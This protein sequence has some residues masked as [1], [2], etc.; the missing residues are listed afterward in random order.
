M[1]TAANITLKISTSYARSGVAFA[2]ELTEPARAP[3]TASGSFLP[4]LPPELLPELRWYLEK[5]L[6]E[7]DDAALARSKRVRES[8]KRSGKR[9]FQEL[10]QSNPECRAIWRRVASR[11]SQTRIEIQES[12][13]SSGIPWELLRDPT[14]NHPVCL[15]AAT[16]VRSRGTS[17]PADAEPLSKLKVLLVISRPGGTADVELR[18]I[19]STI[20]GALRSGSRFEVD[21]LRPPTYEALKRTLREA[22][23]RNDP[24][25]LVHFDGHGFYQNAGRTDAGQEYGGGYLVFEHDLAEHGEPVSGDAFGALATE[26][27]VSAVVLN[28]CRS[29]YQESPT[30]GADSL[31]Q[32]ASSFSHALLAAGVSAAVAMSFN[33]YVTSAKTFMEEFYGQL[34]KG[35][36]FSAAA[37]RA[38]K[39]LSVDRTR[40]HQ[41]SS[42]IDDWLVPAVYQAGADLTVQRS[43]EPPPPRPRSLPQ[44]VPPPP[45]FGFVGSD[46][47]LLQVDRSFDS[48][49]IVLLFGLAGAGKS[50]ASVEFSTWYEETN[51]QTQTLLFTS[52]E[53]APTLAEV[54]ANAEPAI[55]T[56]VKGLDLYDETV[57]GTIIRALAGKGTL[58]TWDNVET[59]SGMDEVERQRFATFVQRANHGGLK[60]LLTARDP[61]ELWLDDTAHRIEMP[62]LR[63]SEA[64]ELT[65]RILARKQV[66]RFDAAV[67]TPLL[68]FAAGNPLTLQ[69]SV[70]SCLAA[71]KKPSAVSVQ[72]YV[73]SLRRGI[74]QLSGGDGSERAKSLTASLNYGFESAFDAHAMKV[75]SLLSLFRTYVNSFTIW[76][77]CRPITDRR[78]TGMPDND[79]SW[80]IPGLQSETRTAIELVLDKA[81]ELGILRKT[82]DHNYWLHPAIHL[83]LQP[84]FESS[85]R[86]PELRAIAGRAYAEAQGLFSIQF[87]MGLQEGARARVIE[88]LGKE[89]DNLDQALFASHENGWKQAEVGILHGLNALL[90]HQG[91][92][93]QWRV[94]F[95][96]VWEDFIG[97]DLEALP[98]CEKWWTFIMDHRL[99]IAMEDQDLEH[100]APIARLIKAF[101]E[102]Q[103]TGIPRKSG[104]RYSRAQRKALHD[105]AIATGRLADVLRLEEDAACLA[106]NEEA[107]AIYKLIDDKTGIAIRELNL[108]HCY[109]NVPSIR[110]LDAAE[111]HYR[112]AYDNY[113][114]TDTL[115]RAQCLAQISMTWLEEIKHR[116]R[117]PLTPKLKEKLAKAIEQYEQVLEGLPPD[118]WGDLANLH[119]NLA[120]A[121][122]FDRQ[123]RSEAVDHIRTAHQYAMAAGRYDDAAVMRANLAQLFDMMDRREEAAAAAEQA[124]HELEAV[125]I[126]NGQ[127]RQ[128]KRIIRISG[129]PPA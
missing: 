70:S 90:M 105:L 100:A 84:F 48:H 22:A 26:C 106:V 91:R 42:D 72:T 67:W 32:P 14:T 36:A 69:V 89:A 93:E 108:G 119:N 81:V 23:F 62:V 2:L 28:A 110:D 9:L 56:R 80:T 79:F 83:H 128:L 64:V 6:D 68:D 99:R 123:R 115:T 96:G 103:T 82:E 34:Q 15:S 118:A 63:P 109:K 54:I 92:Y 85:Y 73:E 113:P 60:L 114:E 58:W 37:S 117:R 86:N 101:E 121:L 19:A 94:L 29:A 46:D 87:V 8:V 75:L 127:V 95:S 51:P 97:P 12:T 57:Q 7:R 39:H 49:N 30:S 1:P 17:G 112:I 5:F 111:A 66:R 78:A 55:G 43:V 98:G 102:K 3:L 61:Q 44:S 47:A 104:C 27:G 35:Q 38:R 10:F 120:N 124:L 21:V 16:F 24:Y 13:A 52:F 76:I 74:A 77:M 20:Y 11:L 53:T 25:D 125:G 41:D 116:E 129:L 122:R 88:V 59:I 4:Q 126:D 33:V 71:T 40:F 31:D 50:A 45:D 18:T 107:L 65:K